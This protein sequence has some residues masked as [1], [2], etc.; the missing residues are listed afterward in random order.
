MLDCFENT[1]LVKKE[2]NGY[3]FSSK[4]I[5]MLT[6]LL[7]YGIE[8][9]TGISRF[10]F[11]VM[12]KPFTSFSLNLAMSVSIISKQNTVGPRVT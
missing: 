2:K 8:T 4:D 11:L 1:T 9:V 10:L 12:F 7:I 3:N 5:G 6:K